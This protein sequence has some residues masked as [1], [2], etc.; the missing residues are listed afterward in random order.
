MLTRLQP[1][2]RAFDPK[3][4]KER[5]LVRRAEVG[6]FAGAEIWAVED[7]VAHAGSPVPWD[8]A[9]RWPW[10]VHVDVVVPCRDGGEPIKVT[11]SMPAAGPPGS[12]EWAAAELAGIRRMGLHEAMESFGYDPHAIGDTRDCPALEQGRA[13]EL[14]QLLAI[15]RLALG[16]GQVRRVTQHEDG[17]RES[18]T[19][20]TVMLALM[21][22]EVAP[23]VGCDPG[24]A[25]QFAV[26][27]DIPETYAG[28][29]NTA[30]GLTAEEAAA[31]AAREAAAM[32]RLLDEQVDSR[33][34]ELLH[35]Y[36]AQ[37]EPEARI[38]R[39]LDKVLPKLTHYLNRGSALRALGITASEVRE[40]HAQQGEQLAARYPELSEVR[41]LFDEA[42]ALVEQGIRDGHVVVAHATRGDLSVD[43]VL[44]LRRPAREVGE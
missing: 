34:L 24:L 28:D 21:V 16:F 25:A 5:T 33:W 15:A 22:I 35:R 7:C 19:T 40:K 32:R 23:L 43:Q 4:G 9:R 36:E 30:H 18:D 10:V 41:R 12:P 6:V 8:T 1:G 14:H 11:F 31:K 2:D 44:E 29:T 27:H 3:T 39:Y 17:E 38:V 37:Q 42:C 13:V 26:V 20:H